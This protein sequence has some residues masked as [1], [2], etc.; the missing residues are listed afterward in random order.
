M[1]LIM[2]NSILKIVVLTLF[3]GNC[4]RDNKFKML[5]N[6]N[7]KIAN[8]TIDTENLREYT[9]IKNHENYNIQCNFKNILCSKKGLG[10]IGQ[11]CSATGIIALQLLPENSEGKY[12]FSLLFGIGYVCSSY[13]ALDCQCQIKKEKGLEEDY[14]LSEIIV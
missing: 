13:V 1:D 12:I 8:K 7:K 6:D 9:N 3:L 10:F 5:A 2:S 14:S 11:T 4:N